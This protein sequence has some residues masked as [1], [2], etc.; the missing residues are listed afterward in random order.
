MVKESAQVASGDLQNQGELRLQSKGIFHNC[1][2][3][4]ADFLRIKWI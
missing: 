2:I 4:A 3:D 1:H